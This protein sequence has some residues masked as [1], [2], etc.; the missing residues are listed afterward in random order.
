MQDTVPISVLFVDDEEALLDLARELLEETGTFTVRT[1][2]SASD[3]LEILAATPCDIVVSDYLMPGMD[4]IGFLKE[5]KRLYPKL[6]FII[7]TGKGKEEVVIEAINN[8]AVFYIRK[9][10]DL[11][12]QF[13]ELADKIRTA[14][15]QARAD[16]TLAKDYS[17]L[18][19][20]EQAFRE[21]E[22]FYR[23]VFET[24]G[25]AM[26]VIEENTIISLT[27]AEC[28]RMSG[29]SR[30]DIEGKKS[31]TEFVAKEDLKQMLEHHKRRREK[32]GNATFNYEFTL[33][34]RNGE[35]RRVFLTIDLIPGT[36][37][38]IASLIDITDR[39]RA[40]EA[41]KQSEA[42]HRTIFEISP[43]AIAI[44]DTKGNLVQASP[45]ALR[46][47]GHDS[48]DEV[49]GR[50]F[51]DW[52]APEM[53]EEVKHR[54]QIFLRNGTSPLLAHVYLMVK[55]D[56][57]QFY[58]DVSSSVL[59]DGNGKPAGIISILRDVTDRINAENTLKRANEKLGL[60]ATV[61]RH[62]I[63]NKL[64]VLLGY[65]ELAQERSSPELVREYLVKIRRAADTVEAQV[66][67]S[68]DYYNFGVETPRWQNISALIR[69][70]VTGLD[71]SKVSVRNECGSLEVFTDPLFGN[72]IYNIIDN[73]LR[74]GRT[75]S[76]IVIRYERAA[77]DLLLILEDDGPGIPVEEK[78][79]IFTRGYGS[80]T[81]LG[82]FVVREILAITGMTIAENGRAGAGARFEI[83][84]PSGYFRC[85][86]TAAAPGLAK[87]AGQKNPA[88][89]H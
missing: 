83:R 78:E 8:G 82:L 25:T 39:I 80:N 79:R 41:L 12:E 21:R 89:Y 47:F 72:V 11:V 38:S 7:F 66:Q 15:V 52:I 34:N 54:F 76:R 81:G 31:W 36:K 29:Y 87:S 37:K 33:L 24:T 32:G 63:V 84:I 43:D 44:I 50:P 27:N 59:R 75:L 74:H 18:Q 56:G 16:N 20:Q 2:L 85:S 61:T 64:T 14:V 88:K 35:H 69:T 22:H 53:R 28:E 77:P 9:G 13:S 58:T 40:E 70:A 6:P 19:Q 17:V 48:V 3:A 45:S 10:G 46:L 68:K 65:I 4:G 51:L 42:L 55:K 57:T 1:A 86:G 30:A 67:V 23:V 73:A 71:C 49:S 60:L 62:D 5:V 26:M